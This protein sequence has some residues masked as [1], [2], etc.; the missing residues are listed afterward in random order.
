MVPEVKADRR[1]VHQR[2]TF[3]C[4]RLGLEVKNGGCKKKHRTTDFAFETKRAWRTIVATEYF[5]LCETPGIV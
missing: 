1:T 3:P 2:M 5:V 4:K